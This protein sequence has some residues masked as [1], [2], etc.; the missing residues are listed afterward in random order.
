LKQPDPEYF[1]GQ[2]RAL[3]ARLEPRSKVHLY[4]FESLNP[5]FKQSEESVLRDLRNRILGE[6]NGL[7]I[8][9][10][11]FGASPREIRGILQRA[12]QS[13]RHETLTAMTIFDELEKLTRDRSVYE[14][15][16]FE[17]RGKYHDV[18]QFIQTIRDD[19]VDIFERELLQSMNLV[20]EEQYDQLLTRY[21]EH[22]AATIKKEKI[23]NSVTGTHEQPSQSLLREVEKIV[24]ISGSVEKHRE[25]MLGRLAARMI[26]SPKDK[27]EVTEIFN[28]MLRK[29][30]DH[31]YEKRSV[32]VENNNKAM[33]SFDSDQ[34]RN[35]TDEEKKLAKVTYEQLEKRFGYDRVSAKESLKF[36]I[37]QKKK[38]KKI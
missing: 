7:V 16:Q 5:A 35:L 34:E 32:L 4:D 29:I 12:A 3:I 21:V 31:Y 24:G 22:V 30:E 37:N 15:L 9:E 20:E 23:Y 1:D 8:Y 26:D 38:R 14:F 2:Y 28:D 10:G 17:P 11:R 36:M 19:Y 13:T 18:S 6:S 25:A 27:I 33:L